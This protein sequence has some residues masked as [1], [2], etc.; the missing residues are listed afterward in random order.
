MKLSPYI[1]DLL[2]RYEL[3]IIPDLGGF[4]VKSFSAQIDERTNT[5]HPPTK[6]LGFN[7][8]LIENDGLLANHIASID[9]IPYE[10]AL[11]FIKFEITELLETLKDSDVVLDKIG[12][13][14]LNSEGNLVF[15]PDNEANFSPESFGLSSVVS[16]VV[17]RDLTKTTEENELASV[18]DSILNDEDGEL[19]EKDIVFNSDSTDPGSNS[20]LKYAAGLAI[21]LSLGYVFLQQYNKNSDESIATQDLN[22]DQIKRIQEAT[23]EV[24]DELQPI[25][26]KIFKDDVDKSTE[27]T[28]NDLETSETNTATDSNTT[29]SIASETDDTTE[30]VE[31]TTLNIEKTENVIAKETDE[32][33]DNTTEEVVLN[34]DKPFHIIAGAFKEIN[35]ATKKVNQLKAKGYN[36]R[37][38]GVNKWNLTQ[39]AFDSYAT[40][41]EAQKALNELKGG[42]KGI[43]ILKK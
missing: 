10:T 12:S 14:S 18:L 37:V 36:A 17:T 21:L 23:F 15:E 25:S 20:F 42:N 28:E 22:K 30:T 35:N 24:S 3:V 11:N 40:K 41:A 32:T 39:V 43:W 4:L 6:R 2:Y 16:P 13:F 29:D 19:H 8:Q 34:E 27:S 1:L 5:I 33:I 26:V 9:K 38:V 7:T 31:K